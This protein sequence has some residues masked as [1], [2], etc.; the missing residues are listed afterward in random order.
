MESWAGDREQE[1][2]F[3]TQC[4]S[5]YCLLRTTAN[6]EGMSEHISCC[7]NVHSVQTY[8]LHYKVTSNWRLLPHRE[9]IRAATLEF[10]SLRIVEHEILGLKLA[11]E[12]LS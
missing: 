11:T 1:Y 3:S 7:G 4:K 10:C 5:E 6:L 12:V 2:F 8:H 9:Y